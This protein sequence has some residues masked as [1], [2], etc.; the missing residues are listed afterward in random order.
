MRITKPKIFKMRHLPAAIV[1]ILIAAYY[2]ER[3]IP[4]TYS[5]ASLSGRIIN[6]TTKQP[7]ESAYVVVVY[8]INGGLE[9]NFIAPLYYEE[10]RSDE[11]GYF[12]F[13][14]FTDVPVDH[15]R[16]PPNAFVA[17]SSPLIYFFADGYLPEIAIDKSMSFTMDGKYL[18]SPFD[19][20]TVKL[21]P[22]SEN[23]QENADKSSSYFGGLANR[24]SSGY[25]DGVNFHTN[26]AL[27]QIPETKE[28]LLR[29]DK[30]Y[31][32]NARYLPEI[33]PSHYSKCLPQ[34]KDRRV[35]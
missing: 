20:I 28:Y 34:G 22:L 8:G 9:G 27:N 13:K 18:T 4:D 25:I 26:C 14:G 15:S 1:L 10:M 17:Y 30:Y 33:Y 32:I 5:A 29:M 3:V 12:H 23:I 7:I 6:K 2:V 24:I 35:D 31:Q 11:E 16:A 21:A 19:G